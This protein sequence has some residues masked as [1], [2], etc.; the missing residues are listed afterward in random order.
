MSKSLQFVRGDRRSSRRH[1]NVMITSARVALH[2][3]WCRACVAG[4]GRAD[5]HPRDAGASAIPT[6]A[7]DYGYLENR[8]DCPEGETPSP[9]LVVKCAL[10]KATFAEVQP[11]KGT[12]HPHCVF[13]LVAILVAL[14]HHHFTVKSDEEPPTI[15]LKRRAA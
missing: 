11:C 10:T 6:V 4:R 5:Q 12:A 14:G 9:V 2:R 7:V 1:S 15:D 8:A 13:A 3:S